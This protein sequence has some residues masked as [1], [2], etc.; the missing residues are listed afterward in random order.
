MFLAEVPPTPLQV[1]L[2]KVDFQ[3]SFFIFDSPN[4]RMLVA[5]WEGGPLFSA[6]FAVVIGPKR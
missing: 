6:F 1:R 5:L 3:N 4:K 2:R